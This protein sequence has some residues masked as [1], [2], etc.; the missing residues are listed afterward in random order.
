LEGTVIYGYDV[1]KRIESIPTKEDRPEKDCVIVD[2]GQIPE[3]EDGAIDKSDTSPDFP[4]ETQTAEEL[5]KI[6]SD[7]KNLGNDHFKKGETSQAVAKYN[8]ALRFLPADKSPKEVADLEISLHS[9]AAA[10]YL[11]EKNYEQAISSCE[12]VRYDDC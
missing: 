12:E 7:L 5:L 8:K 4:L 9:N 2:C 1:V 11:K 3:N 6:A 10:C